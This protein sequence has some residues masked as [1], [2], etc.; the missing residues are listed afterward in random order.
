MGWLAVL[1]FFLTTQSGCL[2]GEIRNSDSWQQFERRVRDGEIGW[3]EGRARIAHWAEVLEQRYTSERFDRRIFF[4]LRGYGI[5]SIGGRNGEGYRPGGYEFL[6]GNRHKGHPAQDVFIRDRDQDGF[7]DSTGRSVE[8]LAL[9][10]GVVLSTFAEW[11]PDE[12][13]RHIRGGNYVWIYHPGLT[14]FSYYAHLQD[15]RVGSGETVHGGAVIGTLGRTGTNAFPPRSP[16]HLHFMLLRAADMAPV[17]PY[18]M[19]AGRP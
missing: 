2:A 5:R 13:H 8:V 17:D 4:P 11:A 9:A 7:D 12:L 18:P 10:D 6:G 16:T 19:F 15:I 14:L 1:G 3:T